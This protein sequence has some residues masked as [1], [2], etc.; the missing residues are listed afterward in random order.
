[1]D[2]QPGLDFGPFQTFM[3]VHIFLK[4]AFQRVDQVLALFG[5]QL[6]FNIVHRLDG[7][8]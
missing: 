2:L 3:A 1:M 7:R 8:H 5:G 4:P 6:L